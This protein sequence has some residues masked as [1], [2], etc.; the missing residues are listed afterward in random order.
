MTQ[1]MGSSPAKKTLLF[2][3]L[4]SATATSRVFDLGEYL[5]DWLD[6]IINRRFI[7]THPDGEKSTTYD[8]LRDETNFHSDLTEEQMWVTVRGTDRDDG[9]SNDL[10]SLRWSLA[11]NRQDSQVFIQMLIHALDDGGFR[12]VAG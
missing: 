3:T 9:I 11:R 12:L 8:D 4:L 2:F 6:K 5:S 7:P 10:L 1:G